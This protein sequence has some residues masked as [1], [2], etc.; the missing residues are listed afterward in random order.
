[1]N[2][3]IIVAS[4][5]NDKSTFIF[6]IF[7]SYRERAMQMQARNRETAQEEHKFS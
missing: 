1:L 3:V 6:C 7:R 2:F 4:T 5:D